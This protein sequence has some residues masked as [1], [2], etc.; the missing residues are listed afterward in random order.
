MSEW[1]GRKII[2]ICTASILKRWLCWLI[3]ILKYAIYKM[4]P[5]GL[6]FMYKHE[7]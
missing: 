1:F 3:Q 4:L 6:M 5:C 2:D 7:H